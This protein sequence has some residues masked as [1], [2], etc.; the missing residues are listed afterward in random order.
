MKKVI[1]I[2]ILYRLHSVFRHITMLFPSLLE[3]HLLY[4]IRGVC[5]V[6]G[7]SATPVSLRPSLR[8]RLSILQTFLQPEEG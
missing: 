4:S 1:K 8:L 5:T 2:I 7:V 6:D 3:P